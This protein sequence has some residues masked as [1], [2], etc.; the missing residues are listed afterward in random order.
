MLFV[1]KH[2]SEQS[3]LEIGLS[4]FLPLESRRGGLGRTCDMKILELAELYFSGWE[5]QDENVV[6]VLLLGIVRLFL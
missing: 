4:A 5:V 2:L 6:E 1:P 3:L